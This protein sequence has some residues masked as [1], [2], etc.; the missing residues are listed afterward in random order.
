MIGIIGA[1]NMGKAIASGLGKKVMMNDT[2]RSK[3]N[4]A[5]KIGAAPARGNIDLVKH[6]KMV[7]L[8]VKPQDI[9]PVLKEIKPHISGKLII[10]IAAGVKT[11]FIEKT[12]GK[13]RV[14]RVMPNMPALVGK[15]GRAHV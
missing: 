5:R 8:A 13:V 10:S 15:I 1:G 11:V 14:I 3:L 7:I 4:A 6:S 2:V 9:E 12:L